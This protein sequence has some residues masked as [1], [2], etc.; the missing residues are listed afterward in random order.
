MP[1]ERRQQERRAK[2][3]EEFGVASRGD[4]RDTMR[5]AL[6]KLRR[7]TTM[8]RVEATAIVERRAEDVWADTFPP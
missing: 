3:R 1:R 2:R 8:I 4:R 5:A 6:R 7:S